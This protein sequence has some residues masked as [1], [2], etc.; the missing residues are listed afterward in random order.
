M[1][2]KD[3]YFISVLFLVYSNHSFPGD[4]HFTVDD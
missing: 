2:L 1:S 3:K 4:L